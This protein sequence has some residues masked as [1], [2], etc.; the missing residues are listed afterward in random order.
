M[1]IQLNQNLE[2][3]K[4][5]I[6]WLTDN[7]DNYEYKS[8]QKIV[9]KFQ[10]CESKIFQSINII[11]NNIK[12][13][14]FKNTYIIITESVYENFISEFLDKMNEINVIPKFIIYTRQ[15][16]NK[17]N[18]QKNKTFYNYGGRLSSFKEILDFIQKDS[19]IPNYEISSFSDTL[20]VGS[21]LYKNKEL[22]EIK[23]ILEPIESFKQMY[24][25]SYY[26]TMIKINEE[27]ESKFDKFTKLLYDEYKGVEEIEDLLSQI[28]KLKNIPIKLL[29]KY[30]VRCYTAKS[31]HYDI[32]DYLNKGKSG[33]YTLFIKMMY[34]GVK[35]KVL[36]SPIK[37]VIY[38]GAHMTNI[39]LKK[40]KDCLNN[41]KKKISAGILF[42]KAFLS[43]SCIK[44]KAVVFALKNTHFDPK[45]MKRV[46]FVLKSNPNINETFNTHADIEKY[47]F[48]P[49]EKEILFLINV[50]K[51]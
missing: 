15:K 23:L 10:N 26:K 12:K 16:S 48:Y 33:K 30:W 47:S 6:Y 50:Y 11:L 41:K 4:I 45:T 37:S 32:N 44:N 13:I 20:R 51:K 2:N 24:L 31:F 14:F 46:L 43:F 17:N 7:R 27:D 34:E 25:P 5:Y 38:R 18:N 29:C 28:I 8:F 49:N 1:I 19:I 9:N 22:H 42:C 3:V 36:E 35:L 21:I 40:I 39:E